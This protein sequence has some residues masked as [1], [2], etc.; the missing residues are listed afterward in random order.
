MSFQ[1]QKKISV[2]CEKHLQ[3]ERIKK[4]KSKMFAQHDNN[5]DSSFSI[6]NSEEKTEKFD[7]IVKQNL[8]PPFSSNSQLSFCGYELTNSR[9]VSKFEENS[10]Q[11][12]GD[13]LSQI[14]FGCD[15]NNNSVLTNLLNDLDKD[16][17]EFKIKSQLINNNILLSL[18]TKA[19]KLDFSQRFENCYDEHSFKFEGFQFKRN[20]I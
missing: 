5:A 17:N 13:I 15:E 18:R 12:G 1:F 4:R 6:E 14:S 3:N 16:E 8:F 9:S 20:K 19:K 11:K 7:N 10:N 2:P